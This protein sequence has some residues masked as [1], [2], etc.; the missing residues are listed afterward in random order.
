MPRN[1]SARVIPALLFTAFVSAQQTT[2][3]SYIQDATTGNFGNAVPFG[4][5]PT[6][7]F[8][9][10][11]TQVL[12][13]AAYLPGPASVLVGLAAIGQSGAATNTSLHYSRLRISVA[14]TTATALNANFANN[15]VNPQVVLDVN[16]LTV[17]WIARAWTD[18]QFSNPYVHDG[19]SSLVIEIQKVVSP[20]GDGGHMTV[21]NAQR[22]DLPRMI[23][24]LGSVGSNAHQATTA[25][26][27][28]NWPL[29]TR[30]RW[31]GVGIPVL[32]TLKLRSSSAG[33]ANQFAIGTTMQHV[34]Q[35][36]P[37]G[38]AIHL[39]ALALRQPPTPIANVVGP[40]RVSGVTL[41]FATIP[42]SGEAT[43]NLVIPANPAL[44]GLYTTF[45]SLTQDSPGATWRFTNAADCF[46]R[47]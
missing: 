15:M 31:Q 19:S 35:G 41:G 47:S 9:E 43:L 23:N 14:R 13:P 12:I 3:T 8:A 16:N 29:S 20:A 10:G 4:C 17:L 38:L 27:T 46:L 6:G 44:V 5:N 37:G 42:P 26:A 24:A 39:Q 33:F 1:L 2:T 30:L 21:Q 45:Q 40:F 34:V 11:R 18:I 36:A 7:L 28:A 32:P 25:T 22:T